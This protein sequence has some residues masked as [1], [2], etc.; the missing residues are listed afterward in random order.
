MI[1]FYCKWLCDYMDFLVVVTATLSNSKAVG[2]YRFSHVSRCCCCCYS[3][4]ALC[5]LCAYSL[6]GYGLFLSMSE[7]GCGR[8]HP[9]G[10]SSSDKALHPSVKITSS[11][12]YCGYTY[13]ANGKRMKT[14]D[15]KLIPSDFMSC[16]ASCL[17]FWWLW[18]WL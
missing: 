11:L 5:L 13:I 4:L 18:M 9:T 8:F 7:Y 16:P 1:D 3:L 6:L 17:L 15:A 10:G 12:M 2:R 14:M